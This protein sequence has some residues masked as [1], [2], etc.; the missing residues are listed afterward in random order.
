MPTK[1]K[2]QTLPDGQQADRL[3]TSLLQIADIMNARK[4]TDNR[5]MGMVL[6]VVL[7]YLGVEQGSLMVLERNRLVVLAATRPELVGHR[8]ALADDSVATWVVKHAAPLFIPDIAR[9]SRF[10][11]REGIYKKDSL[12]SAPVIHKDRVIGVINACDKSGARDLLKDDITHLLHLSSFILWTFLQ[13]GLQKKI[14]AQRNTLQQRNQELRRQE[15]MRSH[16]SRML[17][18]DLKAPL[19][20]VVANLDILSYNISG[21]QKEFLEAAQL[22]CD[23]AVRMVSNLVTT[24]QIADGKLQLLFEETDCCGLLAEAISGVK[25]LARIKDIDLI[26]Q[27]P[28][29][30]CPLITVDRTLILRVLQN[31]LTN[32]LS[33]TAPHTAIT[34][35]FHIPDMDRIEFFVQDEGPGIPLDQ[36]QSIFDKYA[37]ISSKQDALVG[38]GLGLH[39]CKQAVEL[40][41]GRIGVESDAKHGSRFFFILPVR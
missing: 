29:P 3:L 15:E 9:D 4:L 33:Y 21:E 14:T 2:P 8:Q 20:E 25:G 30:E 22:G 5:R 35:G 39:F 23:R 10:S 19:S 37:R 16:L 24:D 32:S 34:L 36:Q 18:H 12:L 41:H 1:T 27:H 6:K 26:Q 7:D 11:K 13:Q 40:H 17:V 31:L 28:Q 38:A